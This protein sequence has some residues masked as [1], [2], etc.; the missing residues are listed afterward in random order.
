MSEPF[1]CPMTQTGSPR[2]RPKPPTIAIVLAEE[3]VAGERRELGDEL[4]DIVREMRPLRM[5]G[6]LDLLPG[7]ERGVEIGERLG[8]LG[9]ELRQLLGDGDALAPLGQRAQFL[10]LGFELGDGLFEIEI[11]AHGRRCFLMIGG[12]GGGRKLAA[13]GSEVKEAPKRAAAPF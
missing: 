8:G 7:S 1:S 9:L 12:L 2:K 6:D 11:G 3:P 13:R 5:A 4:L 10:H